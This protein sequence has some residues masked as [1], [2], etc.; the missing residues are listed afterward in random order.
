MQFIK[1][2]EFHFKRNIL[3]KITYNV[4][5]FALSYRIIS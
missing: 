5:K 3:R 4:T 1:T 2:G